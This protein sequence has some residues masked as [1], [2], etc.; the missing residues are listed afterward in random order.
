[1]D[2][3]PAWG[4]AEEPRKKSHTGVIVTVI[5]VLVLLVCG[6]GGAA[7]WL[8]SRGEGRPTAQPTGPSTVDPSASTGAEPTPA[9]SPTAA[10]ASSADA[11]FA[12]KGQCLANDG[13]EKAPEMRIVGCKGGTY[14]V[15]ARFEGTTDWKNKC[16]G[17]RVPGYQYYYFYD[18][19][20]NTL[21]F[22]LCLKRR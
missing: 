12:A 17:G 15:L 10:P 5:T 13:T 7:L 2:G 6:G 20:L 14:E 9:A 1:V 16:G 19:E 8:V 11:R 21:D 22:V 18:S 4:G 3:G